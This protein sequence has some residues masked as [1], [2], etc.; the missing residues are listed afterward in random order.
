M[1]AMTTECVG[2]HALC[3][4][5]TSVPH[6]PQSLCPTPMPHAFLQTDILLNKQTGAIL[7]IYAQFLQLHSLDPLRIYSPA[8]TF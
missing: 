3:T 5:C 8:L 4:I 1:P 7:Q 6:I 2:L